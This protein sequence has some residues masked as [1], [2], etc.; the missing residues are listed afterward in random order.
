[1]TEHIKR[2]DIEYMNIIDSSSQDA[3]KLETDSKNSLEISA[4]ILP[5]NNPPS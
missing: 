4:E 5:H 1:M 2:D 3:N